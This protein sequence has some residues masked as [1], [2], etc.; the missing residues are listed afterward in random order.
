[1]RALNVVL[2]GFLRP[3]MSVLTS[4]MEHNAVV[5]PLRALE[6]SGVAVTF[7]PC[8]SDGALDPQTLADALAA[9]R[10][11][12]MVLAHASNVCGTVQPL[13]RIA[14]LCARA[15]VPLVLDS[16]QTAGVLPIDA[17]TLGLAALCF[18]GHKSL[19]LFTSTPIP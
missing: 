14:E 7:L 19:A 12:L 6:R 10:Y 13:G 3:G 16:A 2:R 18:T 4:S 8:G 9:R 15:G 11:D 5:R 1:M 17:A